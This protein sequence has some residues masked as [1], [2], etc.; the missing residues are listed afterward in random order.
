MI[1]ILG[2]NLRHS[3]IWLSFGPF[4]EHIFFSPAQHQIHHSTDPR[5]FNKNFASDLSIW[6]W[7][8]GSLY[9]TH[10][11]ENIRVGL[12]ESDGRNSYKSVWD[13]Y[14]QPFHHIFF[15]RKKAPLN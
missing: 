14:V 4:V 7:M 15:S 9:V 3:H 10:G 13:M 2:A 12:V 8:F 11:K 5:H 6:D 1:Y